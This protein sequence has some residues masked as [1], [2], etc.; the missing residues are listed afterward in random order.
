MSPLYHSVILTFV[1]FLLLF[2]CSCVDL[3]KRCD[4]SFADL[5]TEY[6]L[7]IYYFD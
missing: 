6:F 4:T 5:I 3:M 7:H 1:D 2:T